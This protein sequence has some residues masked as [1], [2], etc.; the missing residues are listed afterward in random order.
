MPRTPSSAGAEPAA[1]E[2]PPE[3]NAGDTDSGS[4][5]APGTGTPPLS[6]NR[7]FAWLRSLDLRREQ[8]WIGGVCAGIGVPLG[9]DPLIV[10]GIA[11]VVAVLGGPAILLYAIA[12][13][14]LPDAHDRIH[15]EDVFRGRVEPVIVAIGALVLLSILPVAQGFW[16]LGAGYWG[17]PDWGGAIARALWTAAAIALLV[18]LVVWVARR[19]NGGGATSTGSTSTAG[20]RPMTS[21]SFVASDSTI[22]APS[23]TT[24]AGSAATPASEAPPA[25]ASEPEVAAWREQQARVRAEQEAFRAQ[26]AQDRA[27]REAASQ[28][29]RAARHQREREAYAASRPHPLISLIVIGL[30]LVAG[31]VTVALL[32]TGEP[33]AV[34][35][36]VGASVALAVLALGIIVN[37]I[38]GVRAGGAAG[39]AWLIL[40]PLAFTGIAVAAG[41]TAVRWGPALTLEPSETQSFAVGAGRIQLDLTEFADPD[42]ELPANVELRVGAG[43]ITVIIPDDVPVVFSA[44]VGAGAIDATGESTRIGPVQTVNATYNTDSTNNTD[45]DGD[46]DGTNTDD[47][48][49]LV[50]TVHLGAGHIGVIETGDRR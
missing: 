45:P 46:T 6:G 14:L 3:A 12:W 42:A 28:Q 41:D 20:A 21:A 1:P 5:T 2:T 37:G 29:A 19:A 38:R 35:L 44:A 4:G 13:L 11:V 48:E 40:V 36:V 31:G 26:R 49:P 50:V 8:G 25:G 23:S 9:I 18:V 27:E 39:V 7:F 43:D 24:A 33:T 16:F 34:A 47:T 17:I 22:T 15:L 30:A 10:R 32:S